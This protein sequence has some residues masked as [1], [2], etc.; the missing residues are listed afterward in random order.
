MTTTEAPVPV[1]SPLPQ[2]LAGRTAVILGGSSGIGLAAVEL[3]AS[4]GARGRAPDRR[5]GGQGP[6]VPA[7]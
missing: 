2:S 1:R 4:A 3:L 5:P 7:V 6:E